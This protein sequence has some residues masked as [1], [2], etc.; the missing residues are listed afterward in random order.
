MIGVLA[1]ALALG[2]GAYIFAG[3]VQDDGA[4]SGSG[5][6]GAGGSSVIDVGDAAPD[7]ELPTLDGETVSLAELRG[8]PVIVN[9][10]ASWCNPCREEFPIL[11]E[12]Y[13]E[14]EA[15]G[16]EIVGVTFRDI[17]SDSR[18]FADDFGA[19]WP[20]AVDDDGTAAQAFGVRAIPVT[21]FVDA[22]GVVVARSFGFTSADA[23]DEPLALLLDR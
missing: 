20:L 15:D 1:L 7:F 13:A 3:M 22:E 19:T 6:G 2:I 17:E 10:W 12:T 16:L 11:A 4:S 8:Q 14:H 18:A 23:L 5:S 9:F 21:F